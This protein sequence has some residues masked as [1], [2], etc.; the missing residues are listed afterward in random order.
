VSTNN[1][2]SNV[3]V[4]TVNN[5]VNQEQIVENTNKTIT[6]TY[7]GVKSGYLAFTT[8]DLRG[9]VYVPKGFF[10]ANAVPSSFSVTSSFAAPKLAAPKV[11]ELQAEVDALKAKL[12]ALKSAEQPAA[13]EQAPVEKTA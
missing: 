8:P 12:A 6:L 11:A 10:A 5:T 7:V 2:S 4:N 3:V 9:T 1:S 13:S